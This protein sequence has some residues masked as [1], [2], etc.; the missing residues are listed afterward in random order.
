MKIMIF[1]IRRKDFDGDFAVEG[2]TN[3]TESTRYFQPRTSCMQRD[4]SYLADIV[5][6]AQLIQTYVEGFDFDEFFED[7]MRQDAV[8]RELMVIGEA[9]RQLS[10]EFKD[11]HNDVCIRGRSSKTVITSFAGR[12]SSCSMSGLEQNAR[13]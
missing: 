13:R 12:R 10:G 8:V 2:S 4:V 7:L 11:A 5:D 9:A 6:A 3:R 1:E